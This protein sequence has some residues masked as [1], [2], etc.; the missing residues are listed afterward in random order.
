MSYHIL[1]INHKGKVLEMIVTNL[2]SSELCLYSKLNKYFP[3]AL[4]AAKNAMNENLES[5]RYDIDG[6]ECYY[7]IQRYDANPPTDSKFESHREYIDIQIM[8][9]GEEI[10][11][12]DSLDK[13]SR[14][15]DYTP[16]YELFAMNE[17]YD[18]V[19]LCAGDLVI[20]Y[21]GEAHAPGI[22]AD[23]AEARVCKM[24]VK[25]RNT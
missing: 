3:A 6:D 14:M 5:G 25:I 24:V 7:M 2:K 13:L 10:I 23:G 15:T 9:D 11:R 1:V 22:L 4:E 16:D 21:P 19:R 20:I 8:L 12:F 17:N 18:S